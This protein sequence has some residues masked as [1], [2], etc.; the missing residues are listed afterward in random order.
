MILSKFFD[1]TEI[2]YCIKKMT[3]ISWDKAGGGALISM[4]CS[5]VLPCPSSIVLSYLTEAWQALS[6]R[7]P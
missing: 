5:L 4:S 6:P 2:L 3:E 1:I 7:L